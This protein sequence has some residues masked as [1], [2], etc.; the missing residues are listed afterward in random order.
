MLLQ[1]T[2]LPLTTRR[3]RIRA[4]TEVIP[5]LS[6]T[7]LDYSASAS[8]HITVSAIQTRLNIPFCGACVISYMRM[9]VGV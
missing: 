4:T 7:L 9:C 3:L 2:R 6:K 8:R 5:N 1:Q